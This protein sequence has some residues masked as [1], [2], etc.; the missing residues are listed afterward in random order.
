[1][2]NQTIIPEA[3][4]ILFTQCMQNDLFLN[5]ECR[6]ALPEW[7]VGK[8]LVGGKDLAGMDALPTQGNRIM[9]DD[10]QIAAGPLGRFMESL[11][12]R[13]RAGKDCKGTLHIINIR[14]WHVLD[15]NYDRERIK[16]GAHCERG[17][18]GADYL[19][20]FEPYFDPVGDKDL[21]SSKEALFFQEGS[22]RFYHVH[23]NS[24]FDFRPQF[25]GA[26]RYSGSGEFLASE[27]ELILDVITH[28]S[29]AH[30]VELAALLKAHPTAADQGNKMAALH[31]LVG[32]VTQAECPAAKIYAAV[33][34]VYTD[35][36]VKTLLTGL[37]SRYNIPN[38]AVS[39]TFTA[40]ATLERHLGA[41]DY[42]AKVLNVEV[43]HGINDLV[44]FL[45]STPNVDNER[46]IVISE[47]FQSFY[48][49]FQDKQNVLGYESEKVREYLA[50]TRR[51][52]DEIYRSISR[53]NNFL[54]WWGFGFMTLT[55]LG[56]ALN[57]FLPGKF[58]W[59][60]PAITGGL[61][62][63][64]L[65][66]AFFRRPMKDLQTNLN[67]LT[68]FQM[69]L[70]NHSRKAALARYHLTT[71]QTL[72]ENIDPGAASRQVKA[73][74]EQIAI[75]ERIEAKDYEALRSLV[76]VIELDIPQA[77]V[78]GDRPETH[79]PAAPAGDTPPVDPA[80]TPSDTPTI[81]PEKDH[82]GIG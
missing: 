62:L 73:L 44:R 1:M 47:N 51:R 76:D 13:R 14:D 19:Q 17:T 25:E 9:L 5:Q 2:S 48:R 45:G 65:I 35:I 53:S 67:N 82:G 54:M 58:S 29:D 75:L 26:E 7:E 57:F 56:A 64:Q 38:L 18:W 16:Y 69:I 68:K 36:K 4:Y 10:K 39:D 32:K 77:A 6:L 61:G 27:L 22:V 63:L 74:E 43:I 37:H 46:E 70:E 41:L 21:D 60:A 59:E 50:L 78:N 79:E 12:G 72:R 3:R 23:S 31:T 81:P 33:I 80:E 8:M 66:G 20:G 11:V 40:S 71:P 42:A 28:G 52:S 34:G 15:E 24:V 30:M 55:L 49:Y